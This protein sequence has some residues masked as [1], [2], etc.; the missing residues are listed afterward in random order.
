MVKY[1]YLQL[2]AVGAVFVQTTNSQ[3]FCDRYC[4]TVEECADSAAAQGG[5]FVGSATIQSP[6]LPTAGCF[7]RNSKFWF[8]DFGTEARKTS[9]DATQGGTYPTLARACCNHSASAV[10]EIDHTK[11]DIARTQLIIS[12]PPPKYSSCDHYRSGHTGK[13][14]KG[15]RNSKSSKANS[16]F[17]NGKL[18]F[19]FSCLD[20]AGAGVEQIYD[21]MTLVVGNVSGEHC[22]GEVFELISR[23]YNTR[24]GGALKKGLWN[25]LGESVAFDQTL[26]DHGAAAGGEWWQGS[27]FVNKEVVSTKAQDHEPVRSRS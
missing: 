20:E 14:G 4:L 27:F 16:K 7:S 5:T 12:A 21:G 2:A 25:N 18:T 19:F 13:S 15:L 3:Q 24:Y 10:T 26:A 23:E 11:T 9:S 1:S 17:G 8:G 22:V 6:N